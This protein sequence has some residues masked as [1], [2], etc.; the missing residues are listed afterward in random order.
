MLKFKNI[1]QYPD[2]L[3]F[4]MFFIS[5]F[6][7]LLYQI[8]WIRLAFANFG[9][10]T[11]V[12]SVILSVFM[13][14]LSLGSWGG[15]KYIARLS[16]TFK[17][18]PIIFYAIAEMLIGIG[19][20]VV[21]FLFGISKILLQQTGESDSFTFLILSAV[22]MTISIFP[23]CICMGVTFPFMMAFVKEIRNTE[24][25]SFS[26]LY[27][28][29]V[30]GAM[31]GILITVTL[32]IE[33]YGF[34]NTLW[35]AGAFNFLLSVTA[36]IIAAQHHRNLL[37][38]KT[39]KASKANQMLQPV[40][41]Q[42]IPLSRII[43]FMT[44]FVSIAMEVVWTRLFT[45]ILGTQV[46]AFAGPLFV[47]L[48]ATW[49]GSLL[50]RYHIAQDKHYAPG[51]ILILAAITSFFPIVLNDPQIIPYSYR[52]LLI[53]ISIFPFCATLGYLTPYLIDNY[54]NGM[55]QNA[56]SAYAYN[57]IGSIFGPL[58]AGYILLPYLGGKYTLLI[59]SIP[60]AVVAINAV[61]SLSR[62][63]QSVAT[64]LL[65]LMIAISSFYSRSHEVPASGDYI[66]R[67]DHTATVVTSGSGRERQL[68]VNGV[69]ITELNPLT[70]FM[71][72]LPLG[73]HKESPSE[74]LVICFGM[75]TTYRSLASWDINVTAVELAPSVLD[76]FEEYHTDARDQISYAKGNMVVDDGRRYL[77]RTEKKY[78]VITIDPPPP[79]ESAGSSLLYSDEF[80]SLA[81]KRLKI[82]G[83]LQQW[84]PNVSGEI[85][86][87]GE[88][89]LTK[90]FSHVLLYRG[91]GGY[92]WHYL[93]SMSPIDTLRADEIRQ[94]MPD[95]ARSDLL[96]WSEDES[97]DEY[98]QK[99]VGQPRPV[100]EFPDGSSPLITDDRPYNE[101]F[102]YR[103]WKAVVNQWFIRRF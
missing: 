54:S 36:I 58:I 93:A 43:L 103:R 77:E 82:N 44:G 39:H 92:G 76:A 83:I 20:F 84:F 22:L 64:T 2:N 30:I 26:F 29:N 66:V 24:L 47:Y 42:K 78:D 68:L 57:M 61:R 12:I 60:L 56:G 101:Y 11:P 90:N 21:P 86:Q 48:L 71:A 96:E 100:T 70:K 87:A 91:W 16:R 51:V 74:A 27:L 45:P 99:V 98:I 7:S 14:G 97:I 32:L 31:F 13:L 72:H 62:F 49:Q 34:Q 50:Y 6:C 1:K 25:H 75:G 4:G 40:L 65:I 81:K 19:A 80:Y 23:W 15:G 37:E 41:R 95:R 67:R 18:S 38:S 63:S 52:W 79:V 89:T 5:G 46:Y 88:R 9:V 53:Y 17:R 3:L 102:W 59:L 28:A 10:I 55:P 33:L 69:V 85:L 8:V 73:F 35:I 94:K